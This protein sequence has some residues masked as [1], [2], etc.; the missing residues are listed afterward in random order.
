M[1]YDFIAFRP[2]ERKSIS[3]HSLMASAATVGERPDRLLMVF[4]LDMQLS[5]QTV[6]GC[7]GG[8][9]INVGSNGA[10]SPPQ[11]H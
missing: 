3:Q 10:N 9:T 7:Y 8:I 6:S 5:L 1:D 11:T 4:Q 2:A